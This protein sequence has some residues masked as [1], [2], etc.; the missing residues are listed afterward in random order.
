MVAANT[1]FTNGLV[2]DSVAYPWSSYHSNALLNV[3]LSYFKGQL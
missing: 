2:S 1:G 3:C